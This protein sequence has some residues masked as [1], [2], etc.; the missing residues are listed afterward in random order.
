MMSTEDILKQRG[1]EYGDWAK[2][3][4]INDRVMEVLQ[5]HSN[6]CDLDPG[7]RE[8][9]RRIVMKMARIVNGNSNNTDSWADIAGYAKLGERTCRRQD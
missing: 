7:K 4:L 6:F 2:E 9:L 1:A 8:A 5:T 3:C